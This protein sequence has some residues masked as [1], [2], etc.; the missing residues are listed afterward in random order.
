MGGLITVCR[1]TEGCKR[2]DK[3]EGLCE[4]SFTL[5]IRPAPD[6]MR[7]LARRL[8]A[9]ADPIAVAVALRACAARFT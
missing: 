1:T 7:D 8:E 3:H 5:R 4:L 2:L 9:G 6:V